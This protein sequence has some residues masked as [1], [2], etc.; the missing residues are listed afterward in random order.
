M[1]LGCM[2]HGKPLYVAMAQRKEE[3]KT[4]LQLQHAQKLAGLDGPSTVVIPSGYSPLFYATGVVSHMLPGF[5]W[6]ANGFAPP[7]KPFQQSPA[8]VSDKFAS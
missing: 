6:R 8:V 1:P 3:R 7:T 2:F 5:G 4:L